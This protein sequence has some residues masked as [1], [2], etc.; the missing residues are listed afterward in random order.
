VT[1]YPARFWKPLVLC[2]GLK[3]HNARPCAAER[4]ACQY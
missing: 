2:M 3:P 4:D 1:D